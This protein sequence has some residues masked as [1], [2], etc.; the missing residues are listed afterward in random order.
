MKKIEITVVVPE[1]IAVLVQFFIQHNLCGEGNP[2][3]KDYLEMSGVENP[4]QYTS[5]MEIGI[6][7]PDDEPIK[8]M[9]YDRSQNKA[10]YTWLTNKNCA[11]YIDLVLDENL[12][13]IMC[14]DEINVNPPPHVLDFIQSVKATDCSYFRFVNS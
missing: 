3:F 11:S 9:D 2:D 14:L 8:I 13:S 10:V 7:H 1:D 12:F 5:E 4:S 6:K